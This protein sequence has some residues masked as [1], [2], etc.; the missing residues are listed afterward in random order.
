M[1]NTFHKR[2]KGYFKAQGRY[3]IHMQLSST[4]PHPNGK[5]VLGIVKVNLGTRAKARE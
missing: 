5:A 1:E 2:D 3:F 4:D